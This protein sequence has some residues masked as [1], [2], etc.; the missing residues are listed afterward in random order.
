MI[1]VLIGPPGSGKGTQAQILSKRFALPHLSTGEIF[2]KIV[3]SGDK[4]AKLLSSYMSDGKL[5]PSDFVS[6]ML[7]RVLFL[8]ENLKGCILDGYPRTLDQAVFLS[9]LFP[10]R[11]IA[12]HFDI[13][14]DSLIKR[15]TGRFVCSSCGAIY[16]EYYLPTKEEG[17]CDK[18]LGRNFSRRADDNKDLLLKRLQIYKDETCPIISY[19]RKLGVC[20]SINAD[21]ETSDIASTISRF[22]EK[23]ER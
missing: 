13:Q 23:I 15:I 11:V 2:R 14:D 6:E 4:D 7:K 21:Q 12:L 16:N 8:P 10:Q 17:T 20:F 9:K 3:D 1:I 22:I 5:V 19:Y 18:C